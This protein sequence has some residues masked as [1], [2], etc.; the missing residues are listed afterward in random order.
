MKNKMLTI[1][2]HQQ[3]SDVMCSN[4]PKHCMCNLLLRILLCVEM[5]SKQFTFLLQVNLMQIIPNNS[6][7]CLY[8]KAL[9]E[10]SLYHLLISKATQYQ[11]GLKP[12]L[13]C[14]LAILQWKDISALSCRCCSS[15]GCATFYPVSG[16]VRLWPWLSVVPSIPQQDN[17]C[18]SSRS[19]SRGLRKHRSTIAFIRRQVV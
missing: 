15:C 18:S 19:T 3:Q 17:T 8:M 2:R 6:N 7:S 14:G 12:Y 10:V 13:S 9:I 5:N 16:S 1:T 11:S 4:W